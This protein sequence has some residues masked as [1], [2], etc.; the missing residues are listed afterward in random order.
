MIRAVSLTV[1]LTASLTAVFLLIAGVAISAEPTWRIET[2]A[3]TGK[4][5]LGADRGRADQVNIG[6][7]FGVE[8]GPDG[9][10]YITEVRNHR[11]WRMDR[12]TKQI[13]CIA[14][15]G[16]KGYSG[17][18]GLATAAQ[19]NE[20]YEVRFDQRGD[21][22]FVEMQNHLIRKV[23]LKSG[24]I[25]TVAGTGQSGYG[26]DDGPALEAQFQRPH[27]IVLRG[28]DL[29]VADIGNHRIRKVDLKQGT[30]TSIAG[31]TRKALPKHGQIARGQPVLGPRALFQSDETLWVA[32]REGHSVWS[33]SLDH[34]KWSHVS[35]NG[36]K[37]FEPGTLRAKS[38]TYNGPKGVAVGP[39]GAV[40]VVDTENHAIR[41]IDLQSGKVETIAGAGPDS[42]GYGGDQ[43]DA[44][45]AKM[46]RPH[47][48]CV[49]AD[50][51]VFVGDTLNHR[52]RRIYRP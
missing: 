4:S 40:Y 11:V 43:G 20:P 10:L 8:I 6:D 46:N 39:D 15:N 49:A 5:E 17:D 37:G 24:R 3:G 48:I 23:D 33:L 2:V 38:A 1:S 18:G 31:A 14:G 47:G 35:G 12:K 41:R 7:P 29:F 16:T 50:G 36:K 44:L 45:L 32:L 9:A 13:R 25:S 22:Y 28:N 21:I 52:V 51:S 34:G 19:L 42:G 27:S 26:G 30:V